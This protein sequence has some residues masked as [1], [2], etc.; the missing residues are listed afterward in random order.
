M[1]DHRWHLK[2]SCDAAGVVYS[3][4]YPL[5]EPPFSADFKLGVFRIFQKA[6]TQILTDGVPRELS[7]RVEIIGDT[8][9]CRLARPISGSPSA[10]PDEGLVSTPLHHRAR[11]LGGACQWL[12]TLE[13][14]EVNVRIPMPPA[15]PR[16]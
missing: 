11:Q 16:D 7:L 2:A 6:L 13:G 12:N 8:L 1:F 10:I 14:T 15:T 4:S 9:H 3:E 5:E